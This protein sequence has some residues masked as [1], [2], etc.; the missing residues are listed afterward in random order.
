[1]LLASP[2]DAGCA[3]RATCH[4]V[5]LRITGCRRVNADTPFVAEKWTKYRDWITSFTPKPGIYDGIVADAVEMARVAYPCE[6]V[7]DG[8]FEPYAVSTRPA[9]TRY[10]VKTCHGW[11]PGRVVEAAEDHECCDVVP[12][13]N[14]T[15]LLLSP[16]LVD[17]PAHLPKVLVEHKPLPSPVVR[18]PSRFRLNLEPV[19]V[20]NE[21]TRSNPGYK[22]RAGEFYEETHI[23]KATSQLLETCSIPTRLRM[24]AIDALTFHSYEWLDR[25]S[26]HG[27]K[28]PT[29][30]HNQLVEILDRHFQTFLDDKQFACYQSW[31]DAPRRR[32]DFEFLTARI[33]SEVP[34]R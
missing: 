3:A 22:K 20:E 8:S 5:K 27:G 17:V 10:V 6:A 24:D 13:H 29:D 21:F 11:E 12:G 23:P 28:V 30:E 34:A 26:R 14:L 2:A 7:Q 4:A 31:R 19:T 18:R 33:P 1:M 25:Y 16:K 15:C 9:P 32:N